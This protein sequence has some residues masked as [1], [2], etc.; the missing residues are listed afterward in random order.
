MLTL[1]LFL[2][3]C[4]LGAAAL[5]VCGCAA[6]TSDV[7]SYQICAGEKVTESVP[8]E[9]SAAPVPLR[10]CEYYANGS[11]DSP[12]LSVISAWVP[13]GS[14][15]CI[16]DALPEQVASAPSKASELS[17]I[18]RG[19]SERAIASWLPGGELE[20]NELGQF[21]ASF[22]SSEVSGFL[23]GKPAQIRFTSIAAS[24]SFSDGGQ[25]NSFQVLRSFSEKGSYQ[26]QARI[27]VQIDYKYESQPWAIAAHTTF[28]SSNVLAIEVIEKP[29]R[30]LLVDQ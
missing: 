29:R 1:T 18:F 3:G 12:T 16:G 2:A 7:V 5:G 20:V 30:T 15:L 8:S 21:F 14:R 25:A 11:I 23:L 13:V 28:I 24:W 26:A 27:Q 9:A 6:Q 17:D 19:S 4:D 10:H 22:E